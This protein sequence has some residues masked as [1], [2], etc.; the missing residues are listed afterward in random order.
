[1]DDPW[2]T[3]IGKMPRKPE[4]EKK[5]KAAETL[6]E[7][8][9]WTEISAVICHMEVRLESESSHL[10]QVGKYIKLSIKTPKKITP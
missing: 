5:K 4:R 9:R 3:N 8:E 10:G 2:V 6:G 7:G 1:M